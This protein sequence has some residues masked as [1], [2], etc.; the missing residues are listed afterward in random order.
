MAKIIMGFDTMALY[1]AA[2][3][4]KTVLSYLPSSNR[5][6]L[7]PL[8]KHLQLRTLHSLNVSQ[9]T[10]SLLN[11]DDFGMDFALFIQTLTKGH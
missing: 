6:F 9:L 3:L 4:E 5:A 8:P 7:L 1:T 10:S 2:L 11:I